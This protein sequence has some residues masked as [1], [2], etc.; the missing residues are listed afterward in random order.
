MGRNYKK[1]AQWK[2]K[3][4]DRILF[5]I[6]KDLSCAFRA[7]LAKDGLAIVDFFRAA[8]NKY[9]NNDK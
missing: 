7:K 9:L 6:S 5:D 3:R 1:E 8:I 2:K 4:Y